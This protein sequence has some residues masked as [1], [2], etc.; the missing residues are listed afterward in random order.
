MT[1][2][3]YEIVKDLPEDAYGLIFGI[4]TFAAVGVQ[5]ILALVVNT[6][7]GC[8][9]QTQF[10]IYAGYHLFISLLFLALNWFVFLNCCC[11]RNDKIT[12]T[13]I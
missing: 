1:I 8:D 2:S 12:V 13:K 9:S 4:N 11:L 6:V 5:S 7:L 3:S 10:V